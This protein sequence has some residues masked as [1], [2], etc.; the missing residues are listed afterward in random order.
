MILL[1]F[2]SAKLFWVIE[3]TWC[4]FIALSPQLAN[5]FS[6]LEFSAYLSTT[7][8]G[9]LMVGGYELNSN[10]TWLGYGSIQHSKIVEALENQHVS[11]PPQATTL[12]KC[13]CFFSHVVN[14]KNPWMCFFHVS[15]AGS[16]VVIFLLQSQLG[17]CNFSSPVVDL[18]SWLFL[19]EIC[20]LHFTTWPV[21]HPAARH[22]PQG[23]DKGK[24]ASF[25]KIKDRRGWVLSFKGK[26]SGFF[27]E[28]W[29]KFW[30]F[31]RELFG[32]ASGKIFSSGKLTSP[33]RLPPIPPPERRKWLM[34]KYV[35]M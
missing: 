5:L 16:T 10:S 1:G 18:P 26:P 4:L 22:T 17:S 12:R 28:P 23:Y 8:G 33:K 25:L 13:R 19:S 21:S 31:F 29:G 30:G 11:K 35:T 9:V 20:S 34:Q 3:G 2:P 27:W 7:R 14:Q 24:K 6:A 32:E 15:T